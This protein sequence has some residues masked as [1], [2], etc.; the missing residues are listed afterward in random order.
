MNVN[1]CKSFINIGQ[2]PWHIVGWLDCSPLNVKKYMQ[3]LL[4]FFYS[5]KKYYVE[6]NLIWSNLLCGSKCNLDDL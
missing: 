3:I 6:I 5:E 2:N 1:S 4:M